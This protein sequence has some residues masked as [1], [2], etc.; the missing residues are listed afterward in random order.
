MGPLLV[1]A[2]LAPVILFYLSGLDCFNRLDHRRGFDIDSIAPSVDTADEADW[3][4]EGGWPAKWH[5]SDLRWRAGERAG[6]GSV[7]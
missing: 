5:S 1:N 7:I 4:E 3:T 2:H 6:D